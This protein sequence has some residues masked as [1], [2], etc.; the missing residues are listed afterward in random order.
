MLAKSNSLRFSFTVYKIIIFRGKG[1]EGWPKWMKGS[2]RNGLP[3][4]EGISHKDERYNTGNIV[5]GMV[6]A[7]E[8]DGWYSH[9]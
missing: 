5:G 9:L 3:G 7:L 2:R 4:M 8:G 1:V 6:I